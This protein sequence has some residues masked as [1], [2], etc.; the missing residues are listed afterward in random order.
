MKFRWLMCVCLLSACSHQ[1]TLKDPPRFKTASE[2]PAAPQLNPQQRIDFYQ[3]ALGNARNP[4]NIAA[5]QQRLAQLQLQ[6]GEAQ[7]DENTNTDSLQRS[8]ELAQA[9]LAAPVAEPVEARTE[10]R[11]EMLYQLAKAQ[12]MH[13]QHQQALQSLT[14]LT[15]Q[16]P[17]HALSFESEFRLAE[18]AY[19][20]AD[21]ETALTH[22]QR[23]LSFAQPQQSLSINALYM[24]GWSLFK[25]QQYSQALKPFDQVLTTSTQ[26]QQ[27]GLREDT[28]RMMA[29]IASS[30]QGTQTLQQFYAN[31][32]PLP[33]QAMDVYLALAN[34]Y[35]HDE[36]W[37]DAANVYRDFQ[38]HYPQAPQAFQFQIQLIVFLESQQQ[39][40]D[41]R[42]AKA[43]YV[44]RYAGSQQAE[45]KASLSAY[46]LVLAQFHHHQAQTHQ[47][48]VQQEWQQA[49]AYYQ[50]WLNTFPE[51]P[52]VP[53]QQFLLAEAYF[54]T[55]QFPQAIELY[56][57]LS[58]SSNKAAT[59]LLASYSQLLANDNFKKLSLTEQNRWQEQA[60]LQAQTF[61]QQDAAAVTLGQQA[62]TLKADGFYQQQQFA[63]ADATYRQLLQQ[64]PQ[65]SDS[66]QWRQQLA[67]CL[68][69]QS[70]QLA[71][72]QQ[73]QQSSDLLL[74][75]PALTRDVALAKSAQLDAATAHMQLMQWDNA[76]ALLKKIRVSYPETADQV[77]VKLAF[78]YTQQAN[79]LATADEL[80]RIAQT[81]SPQQQA[82]LLQAAKIY[83]EQQKTPQAI[84]AYQQYVQTYN[85]PLDDTIRALQQ[86]IA[87][88]AG[89]AAQQ[90]SWRREV[91]SLDEQAKTPTVLSRGQA[92]AAALV[93]SQAQ[94]QQ[95]IAAPLTLPLEHSFPHKQQQMQN[96]I[97]ATQQVLA[98]DDAES[99][100]AA[101][102]Q[103]AEI[104]HQFSISL[105]Q[106]PRP[107]DLDEMALE[108]YNLLLEE[109][110]T[111]F[112]DQAIEWHQRN[113]KRL[114]QGQWNDA[115]AHSLKILQQLV[116]AKY[117]RTERGEVNAKNN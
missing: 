75:I 89:N 72:Q 88:N 111:P 55:Q 45:V 1:S 91:I 41:A 47:G 114:Q 85:E 70:K 35:I 81:K 59:A 12:D 116:P 105:L 13:G 98:Y 113:I 23:V 9:W 86:L 77:A 42:Q 92:A 64:F 18:D 74:Q 40:A 60:L 53:E 19:S 106:S 31:A 58:L 6:Q 115:I 109:Q 108:E 26:Q 73:W 51:D 94:F 11:A 100:A 117:L 43:D 21:Y 82:S 71:A 48:D 63:Q 27:A 20:R 33:A 84:A 50:Q 22:Y 46:L 65:A 76:S 102:Y 28:L 32:N 61:R 112:E 54:E 5:L 90:N 95:F 14:Q 8:I 36:R 7:L 17:D 56:S 110:A 4:Q 10:K 15:Q 107:A 96:A 99:S 78:I 104:F 29:V 69:Q 30:L 34:Y 37:L 87:L 49:I 24:S 97:Q 57:K 68:Y 103:M 38:Q 16:Y 44:N 80:M 67:N 3:Q 39:F 25:L 2:K 62:L 101:I 66:P 52:K 83:A 93:L 79:P